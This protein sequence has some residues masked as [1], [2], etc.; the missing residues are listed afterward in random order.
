MKKVKKLTGVLAMM[1]ASTF[2]CAGVLGYWK[3]TGSSGNILTMSSFKNHGFT[4]VTDIITIR[5]S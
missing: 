5:E 2:L 1:G 4:A 3:I